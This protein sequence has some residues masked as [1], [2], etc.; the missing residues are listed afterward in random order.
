MALENSHGKVM[1]QINV[2]PF[3]DVM[4]VL[5]IIFM[6]TAPM[7]QQGI[8]VKLPK[9][10]GTALDTRADP[11]VVTIAQSGKVFLNRHEYNLARL[12]ET[13]KAIH[14]NSPDKGVFLKADEQ[15]A[16]GYVIQT[17][18]AIKKAGVEKIG[19]VTDIEDIKGRSPAADK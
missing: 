6:V 5:L 2:T 19:M 17:M 4:L 7:F 12:T 1:S 8:D 15:V 13:L 14:R 10:S 9:A 11:L 3:V 16:Y 18:A